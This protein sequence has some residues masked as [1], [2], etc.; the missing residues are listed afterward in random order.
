MP[1]SKT[2]QDLV[3]TEFQ[4]P[5]GPLE[6]SVARI[7]AEVLGVDRMGRNDSFFDFGGTSMDAI[8]ICARIEAEV[9][10]RTEPHWLFEYDVLADLV[11]WI[12][13]QAQADT[14]PASSAAQ[15]ESG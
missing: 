5:L 6:A 11:R 4:P 2:R 12:G 8:K 1:M 14:A 15:A 9:G 7:E 13:S 10:Y 3:T